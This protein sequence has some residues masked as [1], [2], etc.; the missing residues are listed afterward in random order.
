MKTLKRSILIGAVLLFCAVNAYAMPMEDDT[1]TVANGAYGTTN[2]GEFLLTINGGEQSFRSFCLEKNES[3]G[4]SGTYTVDSVADYASL[5]GN[6]G[7]SQGGKDFLEEET[8][9]VFWN[10][11]QGKWGFSDA[12]ADNVQRT[13]WQLE[14]EITHFSG[15]GF[16]QA[17][18]AQGDYSING[19]VMALNLLNSSGGHA[20][21]QLI[22]EPVPEPATMMLFGAGLVGL[23]AAR[24]K[25]NKQ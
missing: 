14:G 23:A 16:Y 15:S 2:G 5:G 3:I 11:L 21:S 13:V 24:R 8:K 4:Y 17:M 7:A 18:L 19:N 1:V 6:D 9:W 22:A 12:A 10:Y 25:K 20:Q